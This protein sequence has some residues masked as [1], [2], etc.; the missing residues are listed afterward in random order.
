MLA[1]KATGSVIIAALAERGVS[2]NHENISNWK[3]GGFVDSLLEQEW[4]AEMNLQREFASDL[5]DTNDPLKFQQAV[6]QLAVTQIFQVLKRGNFNDDPANYT[7]LLNALCRLAREAFVMKKYADSCALQKLQELKSLDPRRQ[8]TDKDHQL[9]Y[10]KVEEMFR[11]TPGELYSAAMAGK[12]HPGHAP[13]PGSNA[14]HNPKEE[15][16]STKEP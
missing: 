4:Q 14:T 13:A 2:L 3:H 6:I 11:L 12:P 5:L 16:L 7:R 15:V 8:L 1:V 9:W 10:A